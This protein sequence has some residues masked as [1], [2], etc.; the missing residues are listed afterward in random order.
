[1][2]RAP[3]LRIDPRQYLRVLGGLV[4]GAWLASH[5]QAQTLEITDFKLTSDRLVSLTWTGATNGIVVETSASLSLP[6]WQAVPGT[7]WPVT[8][9]NW[10]GILPAARIHDF[11]RVVSYSEGGTP[12]P[13]KTISL[14][15]IGIHDS[16]SAAYNTNCV[17][18]H[19]DRLNEVAL[20]GKTP[21]AHST[22]QGIFGTGNK[23]C[24]KCHTPGPDF[25]SHSAGG[26]REPVDIIKANCTTCHAAGSEK[27]F[28]A[29]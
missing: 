6:N 4:L 22:M 23:R 1:M 9:T 19:G 28:Y 3:R 17:G 16:G 15:L 27:A 13:S 25:L 7:T 2:R 10:S 26:L 8:G 11:L 20:D 12:R 18:C 24:L 29:K 21:S 5:A 14:N